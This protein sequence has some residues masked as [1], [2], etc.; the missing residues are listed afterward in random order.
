[1]IARISVTDAERLVAE[2]KQR[3]LVAG[4]D[5]D[6]RPIIPKLRRLLRLAFAWTRAQRTHVKRSEA[7]KGKR[8]RR[9]PIIV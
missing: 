4:I 7:A 5:M 2:S 1:M 8:K 6:R 9:A 3:M